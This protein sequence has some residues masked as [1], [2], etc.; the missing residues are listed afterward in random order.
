METLN[1][2]IKTGLKSEAEVIYFLSE[3]G[4]LLEKC[5]LNY[6]TVK[7]YR[8][9]VQH[10]KKN[11]LKGMHKYFEEFERL[12]NSVP[13]I[14]MLGN[15]FEKHIEKLTSFLELRKDLKACLEKYGIDYSF[16]DSN[17]DWDVFCINLLQLI[18]E[19]PIYFEQLKTSFER[20]ELSPA[21]V[22]RKII[23][24]LVDYGDPIMVP[25]FIPGA[26]YWALFINTSYI[27]LSGI[28][29]F[30]ADWNPID[31][32]TGK[33]IIIVPSRNPPKIEDIM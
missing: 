26:I 25:V 19:K 22:P 31:K 1:K 33:P 15:T 12:L 14:L 21:P 9:W 2:I 28:V 8:D 16:I 24:F 27:P 5:S 11:N 6:P 4:V 18:L 10:S 7:F 23:G 30:P 17:K 29:R 13:N 32:K 20:H 3:L